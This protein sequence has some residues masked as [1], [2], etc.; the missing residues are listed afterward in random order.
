MDYILQP[1]VIYPWYTR[2]IQYKEINVIYHITEKKITW[3][4]QKIHKKLETEFTPIDKQNSQQTK[5]RKKL[6][7]HNKGHIWKPTA[8]ITLSNE[9]LKTS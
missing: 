7:Q 4:S 8:N 3:I 1:S 5:N 9:K 6:P 2:L